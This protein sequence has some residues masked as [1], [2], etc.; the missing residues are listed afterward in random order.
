MKRTRIA[1]MDYAHREHENKI[2]FEKMERDLKLKYFREQEELK[3][4]H[5]QEE[6]EAKLRH[7]QAEHEARMKV[8]YQRQNCNEKK[9]TKS[10][11]TS[12]DSPD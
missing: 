12:T 4:K 1:D 7:C 8:Y 11:S 6:H 2:I 3:I 5:M 9:S 10:I